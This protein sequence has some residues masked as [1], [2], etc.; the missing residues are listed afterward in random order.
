MHQ[1]I[2][3]TEVRGNA[4]VVRQVIE[5]RSGCEA[6]LDMKR[7]LEHP[8]WQQICIYSTH[9]VIRH[10]SKQVRTALF[11]RVRGLVFSVK[12]SVSPLTNTTSVAAY[13]LQG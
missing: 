9:R 7:R 5:Y 1:L 4:L 10:F 3:A 6:T 2:R 8:G 12:A 11:A 13:R